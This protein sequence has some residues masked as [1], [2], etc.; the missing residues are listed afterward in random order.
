MPSLPPLKKKRGTMKQVCS[1]AISNT[2]TPIACA[3]IDVPGNLK[4]LPHNYGPPTPIVKGHI[5]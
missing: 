5:V 4:Q 1:I 2:C 3:C